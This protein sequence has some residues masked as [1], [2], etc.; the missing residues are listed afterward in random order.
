MEDMTGTSGSSGTPST[1]ITPVGNPPYTEVV[2]EPNLE[3]ETVA[4]GA[5]VNKRRRKKGPGEAEAHAP[6]KVLR[7]DHVTSHLSQSTLGGKS[8]APMGI[9]MGPT[10]F[11]PTTQETPVQAE[12][13]SD[14]DLLSK[15]VVTKDPDSKKSTSFNSMVGSPRKLCHLPNDE[16]L[17]QYNTTLVRQVAM[18]S[19]LRLRF[20]QETKLLK[21][22]VAQVV[23]RDQRIQSRERHINILKAVLEDKA[24]MK[25][26]AEAK[27]VEV[28]KELKSL[29][30]KFSDLQVS[31]HHLSQ[32]VST[33]QAQVT[34]K[35]R[36]K[37]AFEEF[38]K[39]E[40]D[41]VSSRCAEIDARLDA[42]SI[43]FH[44]ELYPH[45]LMAIAG[46]RCVIRHGLRLASIKCAESTEVRHVFTDVVSAGI[47]KGMSEGLKHGVEHE[48]AKVDL[49]A[50]K[51]YDPKADTK[52]V[53]ALHALKD[54]K[55]PL[56]DQLD[57]LKD[58]PIYVIMSSLYL[59]K[60]ILLED[61]IVANISRDK[62][63]K[64]CRVVCRTHGVGSAHHARSDGIPVSVPTV[65]PQ[66]LAILLAD[67]A[68]Q[69][70]I[71]EDEA[72]PKLLRSK[73]LPPMY[74]LDWP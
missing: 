6:P 39:Y 24:D 41:R 8:L 21:K 44:E 4:I 11:A 51:A 48:K 70:D 3:K 59:E 67:A 63:K 45:M 60:E 46:R 25:D 50:I 49:M 65:T 9:G 36:I 72:S 66:G 58:S 12:G 33:L 22:A 7:K 57:K 42:L 23:R 31:N 52:Y 14:L 30:V 27:N 61:A 69:T 56:V 71:T 34:S 47:S 62:K 64:K 17:N 74:N 28:L 55:Y 26:I 15:V 54:L 37:A 19:Q 5:L 38:K 68:T 1:G 13:V 40:D 18:G 10:I 43:Y 29:R 35:E 20:E 73:S 32:Q 53:A 16:F 2:P